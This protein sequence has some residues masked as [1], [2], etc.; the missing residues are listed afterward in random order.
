MARKQGPVWGA[1]LPGRKPSR[2]RQFMVPEGAAGSQPLQ[3]WLREHVGSHMETISAWGGGEAGLWR[4]GRAGRAINPRRSLVN[5]PAK[6]HTQPRGP[7]R[8]KTPGVPATPRSD[9]SKR[10]SAGIHALCFDKCHHLRP[11]QTS[12]EGD[13][14]GLSLE[15]ATVDQDIVFWET[16]RLSHSSVTVAPQKKLRQQLKHPK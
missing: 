3:R 11:M 5:G 16:P 9:V 2:H 6:Q 14:T 7:G 4:C 10:N 12:I 1:E 13:V 15:Q 8:K